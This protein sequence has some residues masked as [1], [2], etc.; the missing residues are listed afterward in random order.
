MITAKSLLSNLRR[1]IACRRRKVKP[2]K[3]WI[4]LKSFSVLSFDV[5]IR[6]APVRAMHYLQP[7]PAH[8]LNLTQTGHLPVEVLPP[9]DSLEINRHNR[10]GCFDFT[11]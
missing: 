11:G 3:N 9:L 5:I 8:R 2:M 7:M 10:P 1:A 4:V 6:Q